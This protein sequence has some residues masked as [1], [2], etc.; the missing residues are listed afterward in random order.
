[1]AKP[2]RIYSPA[3][4][5]R[6]AYATAFTIFMSYFWLNLKSKFRGTAYYDK[7]I[8]TL[9][10]KNAQRI[11]TTIQELQGLF[12]K[13]GQLIS[14]LSNILPDAFRAPLAELQDRVRPRP[15]AEV[16]QTIAA[17]LGQPAND[18]FTT[19]DKEALAAASIGQVHRATIGEEEV[20]IKIQHANIETI[21]RADLAI[22]KNLVRIHAF[23][24]DFKGLTQMYERVRQMIEEELDYTKEAATMQRIADN[25]KDVPGLEVR[26]PRV[27]PDYSRTK[28]LVTSYCDGTKIGNLDEIQKWGID[29][30]TVAKRMIELYCKMIL[31]DGFYHADPHPGNILVNK[32]GVITLLDFGATANLNDNMKKAIPELIEA[33]VRNDTEDTATALRKMGFIGPDK[34]AREFV[35]KLIDIFRE[36]LQEEVQLDGLNFQNIKLNSGMSSFASLLRQIDLREVS[37]SIIIPKDYILLNRT[38]VLLMGNSYMLAPNLNAL[39]VVR[40]YIKKHILSKEGGI[41]QMILQSVKNQ[42]TAA[43]ALPNELS[44]FLKKANKGKL[45][46]EVRGLNETM[47]R[48]HL[49]GQQFLYALL[50]FVALWLWIDYSAYT[51]QLWRTVNGIC[52]ALFVWLFLRTTWKSL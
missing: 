9:H 51:H 14:N 46:V 13:I 49:L 3:Y 2:P 40:P 4:R 28:I 29:T 12:V 35:E 8:E 44:R 47:Y 22:L 16:E 1:M 37:N 26:V 38:V 50:I 15:F 21:A 7:R 48:L 18:L 27:Y 17:Q 31:V 32:E 6:K 42:L 30:E 33:I 24:M 34:A 5:K 10:A 25:L 20:V 19:I 41:S 39:D 52:L 36:F 43:I 45:E 23:F 11:K